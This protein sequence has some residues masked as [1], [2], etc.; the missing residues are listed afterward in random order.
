MAG[1]RITMGGRFLIGRQVMISNSRGHQRRFV[2]FFVITAVAV[3]LGAGTSQASLLNLN[4][5]TFPDFFTS[6]GTL[7]YDSMSDS[8]TMLGGAIFL[9]DDGVGAPEMVTGGVFDLFA[10]V[11]SLG[12]F[13]AGTVSITG[14]VGSFVSGTLLTGDLTAFGFPTAARSP[15]EFLFSVTGGDA[16][17]LYGGVGATAGIAIVG[18]TG[19]SSTTG[20]NF[21]FP[22]SSSFPGEAMS[23]TATLSTVPEPSTVFLI[24]LGLLAVSRRRARA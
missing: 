3:L 19:C 12:T 5:E 17:G 6:A 15:L 24:G 22:F 16:A 18:N 11:D 8:L 13:S 7:E 20:C 9:D 2:R 21:M 4:L 23:D 1:E 10:S 14:T